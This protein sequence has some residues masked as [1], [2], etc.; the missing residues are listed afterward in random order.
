VVEVQRQ[1]EGVVAEEEEEM[2]EE[3]VEVEEEGE[4]D[5]CGV[6]SLQTI[7]H[8]PSLRAPFA[9]KRILSSTAFWFEG[10]NKTIILMKLKTFWGVRGANVLN[11]FK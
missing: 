4:A 3:E 5:A 6:Y 1:M 8:A 11:V 7:F 10:R 9:V 2:V